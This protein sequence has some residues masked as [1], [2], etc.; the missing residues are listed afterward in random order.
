MPEAER[1][2][3]AQR[4]LTP[5]FT[6]LLVAQVCFGYAFSSWFLLPKFLVTELAARP[7]E[8]G[9]VTAL[10][11]VFVVI[12]LPAMGVLVDRFGR[13]VFLSAGALLMAAASLA[14]PA[15]DRVVLVILVV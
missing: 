9:R 4:L 13:R 5:G 10:H 2:P 14:F 6:R 12:F 15:I 11:G 8:I 3:P 7:A 1:Q